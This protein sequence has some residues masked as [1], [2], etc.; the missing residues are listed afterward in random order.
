[1]AYAVQQVCDPSGPPVGLFLTN[2]FLKLNGEDFSTSRGIAV[3]LK[4]MAGQYPADAIRL[5]TA[6]HAPET[7]VKNFEQAHF[8]RWL[9][10]V[11]RPLSAGLQHAVAADPEAPLVEHLDWA[12]HPQVL[13]WKQAA[14]LDS[15][16]MAGMAHALIAFAEVLEHATPERQPSG[17]QTLRAMAA[18]LCPALCSPMRRSQAA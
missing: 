13:A 11:Y 8:V 4:D 15:F 5:Y 10:A 14:S 16:S 2:R 9:D 7:E 1:V 6:C 18:P 3:W 12:E 17:W